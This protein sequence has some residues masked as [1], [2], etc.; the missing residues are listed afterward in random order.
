MEQSLKIDETI[1]KLSEDVIHKMEEY[2]QLKTEYETKEK[3]YKSEG[4]QPKCIFCKRIGGTIFKTEVIQGDRILL[5]YCN[6]K[7][8]P[9]KGKIDIHAGKI[10]LFSDKMR[11][12]EIN[13]K[14]LKKNVI[15]YKND[16]LFGYISSKKIVEKFNSIKK[17][18]DKYTI[19]YYFIKEKYELYV[20]NIEDYVKLCELEKQSYSEIEEIRVELNKYKYSTQDEIKEGII[21]SVVS[22][23]V[24]KLTKLLNNILHLKYDNP[25][26]ICDTDENCYKLI[27]IPKK[28]KTIYNEFSLIPIKVEDDITD[29]KSLK[30]SK[31]DKTERKERTV[32]NKTLK[33]KKKS[34]VIEEEEGLEEVDFIPKGSKI[35]VETKPFTKKQLDDIFGED[36]DEVEVKHDDIFGEDSD[37]VKVKNEDIFGEDSDDNLTLQTQQ[38]QEIKNLISQDYPEIAL[39]NAIPKLVE[40]D[41]MYDPNIVLFITSNADINKL[42][43]GKDKNDKVPADKLSEFTKLNENKDWR[44]KL[45]NYAT[46]KFTLDSKTWKTVEQYF[47]ASK[48]KKGHPEIYEKFSLDYEGEGIVPNNPELVISNDISLAK[49]YGTDGMYKGIKVRPDD[50]NIDEDFVIP[51]DLTEEDD[52]NKY[53]ENYEMFLAQKAKFT[54]NKSMKKIL[55]DTKNAKLIDSD[56]KPLYILM[57]VRN[58]FQTEML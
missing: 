22:I 21:D 14:E 46:S 2:Y 3:K 23:Y 20:D 44:R 47:H 43:A 8:D 17:Q 38:E 9:C 52:I 32:I 41:E 48:F 28:Y 37:E 53:R 36:S 55:L 58:L 42:A 12:Y 5:A 13:I 29:I 30:K 15:F 35:V 25:E 49:H 54:Q 40:N 50:I 11:E 24:D 56:K 26:V 33:S 39:A 6:V 1:Y 4:K 16:L 45:S 10:E 34:K 31:K 19:D 18:I 27:E 57:Y 7:P 51:L